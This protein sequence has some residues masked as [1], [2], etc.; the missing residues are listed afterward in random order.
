MTRFN[1]AV[2]SAKA[3]IYAIFEVVGEFGICG[4]IGRV[5][6]SGL[7]RNDGVF[8]RAGMRLPEQ[9]SNLRPSG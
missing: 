9:D 4:F 8:S 7:R 2:I 1:Y 5:M 3:G 6:D